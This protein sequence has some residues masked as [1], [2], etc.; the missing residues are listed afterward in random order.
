M[1]LC[2]SERRHPGGQKIVVNHQELAEATGNCV[3]AKVALSSGV[4]K[5]QEILFTLSPILVIFLYQKCRNLFTD[6]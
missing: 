6:H 2:T 4:I 3:L 1:W 5:E